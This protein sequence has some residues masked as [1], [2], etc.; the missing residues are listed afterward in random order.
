[1]GNIGENNIFVDVICQHTK[2][3]EIIPMRVRFQDEDGQFQNY[4]IK[5]YKELTQ[6]GTYTTP[7]GTMAHSHIWK[8][9]CKIQVFN[10]YQNIELFY[11]A[12]DNLWKLIV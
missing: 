1:M 7:Y 3:G 2:K 4:N 5:S 12:T 9:A 6:P 8:F 10:M 11:N